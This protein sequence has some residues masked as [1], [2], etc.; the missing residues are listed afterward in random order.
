MPFQ[1]SPGVN[2]SEVDLSTVI[3]GVATSTGAFVGRFQ[4]GPVGE[5][6]LVSSENQLVDTF[7]QP[8]ANT[9]VDFFTHH[10]G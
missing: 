9:A 6:T 5:R 1:I 4:W 8:D 2:V 10:Y 3:P 7:F